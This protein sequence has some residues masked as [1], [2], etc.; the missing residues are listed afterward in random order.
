MTV[1]FYLNW[2]SEKPQEQRFSSIARPADEEAWAGAGAG[3]GAVC[4]KEKFYEI[5]CFICD[6]LLSRYELTWCESGS[7]ALCERIHK[8]WGK[9]KSS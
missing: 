8:M 3:A 1:I 6:A 2:S 5:N 9:Q 7:S 4:K